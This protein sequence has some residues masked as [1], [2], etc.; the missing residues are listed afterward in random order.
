LECHIEL[1][2]EQLSVAAQHC[3]SRLAA[4]SGRRSEESK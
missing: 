4:R 2:N 1:L 3:G